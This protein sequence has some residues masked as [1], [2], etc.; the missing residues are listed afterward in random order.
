M[1]SKTVDGKSSTSLSMYSKLLIA[2]TV[3]VIAIPTLTGLLFL[4]HRLI[5]QAR[6]LSVVPC[7]RLW[8]VFAVKSYAPNLPDD[9][10]L[11]LL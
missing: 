7:A 5:E 6:Y 11:S 8:A 1:R 10:K 2:F 3:S 4:L 9:I